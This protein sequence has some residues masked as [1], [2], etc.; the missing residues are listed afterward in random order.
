MIKSFK[1]KGLEKFYEGRYTKRFQANHANRFGMRLAALDIAKS[2][3][4]MD[5]PGIS[6]TFAK[7]VHERNLVNYRKCQLAPHS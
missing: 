3:D 7:R 1:H 4:D 6:V 2:S 5:N